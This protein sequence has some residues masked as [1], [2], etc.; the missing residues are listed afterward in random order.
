MGHPGSVRTVNPFLVHRVSNIALS[1][2]KLEGKEMEILSGTHLIHLRRL[3]GGKHKSSVSP[4]CGAKGR[5]ISICLLGQINPSIRLH[6][7]H[8]VRP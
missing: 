5:T 1:V 4:T 8:R 7:V 2:L 6:L 3:E